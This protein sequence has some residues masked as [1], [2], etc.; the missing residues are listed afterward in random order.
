M[1][2][3]PKHIETHCSLIQLIVLFV[4]MENHDS[5]AKP[6]LSI[7]DVDVDVR[8]NRALNALTWQ[9]MFSCVLQV[10]NF[11]LQH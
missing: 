3:A 1:G 2:G 6:H 9:I 8:H 10:E 4:F 7:I 5:L 11:E